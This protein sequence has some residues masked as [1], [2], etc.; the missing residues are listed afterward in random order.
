METNKQITKRVAEQRV[1]KGIDDIGDPYGKVPTL[2]DLTIKATALGWNV[3]E[4]T[5]QPKGRIVW[6]LRKDG[7]V[8]VCKNLYQI[9]SFLAA[10]ATK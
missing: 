9:D 5:E 1:S 4:K 3:S 2:L 10:E 6:E 8:A 7:K